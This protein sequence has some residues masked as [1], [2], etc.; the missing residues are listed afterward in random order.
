MKQYAIN[1]I[2]LCFKG[3]QFIF[4]ALMFLQVALGSVDISPKVIWYTLILL[5]DDKKIF[6]IK[7]S[8]LF[9][10][11]EYFSLF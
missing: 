10:R 4:K 8:S 11:T 2:Y 6:Y 1:K 3:Y 7:V 5:L 9:S